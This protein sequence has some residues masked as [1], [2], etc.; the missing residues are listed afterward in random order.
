MFLKRLIC[1][2]FSGLLLLSA[3]LPI[4]AAVETKAS[5]VETAKPYESP[6]DFASLQKK[7]RDMYAWIE[8]PDTE[9]SFP[10]VQ[11]PTKDDYYLN[12]S[13]RKWL[14]IYGAIY[15]ER[16]NA[17]DF[18]DPVTVVYGHSS[19]IGKM[20]GPLEDNYT[21]REFFDEH[22]TVKVYLPD[23]ELTYEIF[24]AV[25]YGQAHILKNYD[26][27]YRF[28]FNA[29]IDN[30][31]SVRALNANVDRQLEPVFGDKVLVLSTCLR[32][33]NAKQR[34]LVLAK[35]VLPE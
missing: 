9:I 16:A 29:F 18:S 11:H 1:I 2:V 20:F 34:Y 17:K 5:T 10:V 23:R 35:Q 19:Y 31:M 7:H 32:R 6:I 8:I 28:G 30:I 24:A 15:T 26:F 3:V 4:Y 21:D 27:A 25:P 12:H 33:T 14:S 22:R 13:S